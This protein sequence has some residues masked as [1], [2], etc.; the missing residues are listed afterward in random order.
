MNFKNFT[1]HNLFENKIELTISFSGGVSNSPPS[2]IQS[3]LVKYCDSERKSNKFFLFGGI[4]STR[5]NDI[6]SCEIRDNY[7]QWKK[8]NLKGDSPMTRNGHTAVIHRTEMFI[9]GG[10]IEDEKSYRVKEDILI[11]DIVNQR[12]FRENCHNKRDLKW[13]KHHIAELIGGYMLIFG[14]IDEDSE[15]LNDLWV[16]NLVSL[17]WLQVEIKGLTIPPLAFHCS[18][19]VVPKLKREDKSFNIFKI[20]N[21]FLN[22]KYSIKSKLKQEGVYIFGGINDEMNYSNGLYV[23][24]LNKKPFDSIL[25]K[26]NGVQ[27][28]PRSHSKINFYEN[29][30][31]LIL[32]GGKN[33]NLCDGVTFNDFWVLDLENFNWYKLN[34]ND[35]VSKYNCPPRAEYCSLIHDHNLFIFGGCDNQQFLGS[36]FLIANL[37]I[38][39]HKVC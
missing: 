18:A 24:K 19:V 29:T 38:Y 14:G 4:N 16:L 5:L 28:S 12:F 7:F 30:N 17:T 32:H 20:Y 13:R 22:T 37:D 8:L 1:K 34:T 25:L 3:T 31:L 10:V 15:H 21:S 9:W 27:P 35:G 23:I 39:D 11:F 6:W 26:T 33:N 36:D 2:R